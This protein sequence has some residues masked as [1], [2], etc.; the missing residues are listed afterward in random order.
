MSDRKAGKLGMKKVEP[1]ERDILFSRVREPEKCVVPEQFG[2]DDGLTEFFMYGN[3]PESPPPTGAP[4]DFE[5]CGDCFEAGSAEE[6]R[7]WSAYGI[8]SADDITVEQVLTSYEEITGYVLGDE[9]TDQGT[10]PR[11]GLNYRRKTG[12]LD[13]AGARHKIGLYMLGEPGNYEQMLELAL[14]CDGVGLGFDI[15]S[16][17]QEQ[18]ENHEPWDVVP[19]EEIEGGHWVPFRRR[20]DAKTFTVITW[21][22]EQ[23]VTQ[24]FFEKRNNAV[25]G[26]FS[27]ESLK[28]GKNPD[29]L[30]EEALIAEAKKLGIEIV[31][32][33]A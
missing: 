12:I 32:A 19:D 16:S 4:T 30:D 24:A 13:V 14:I 15:P 3:G 29:G 28:A 7:M 25:F 17:A 11:Q 18:F 33:T 22:E 5:G 6:T 10:E 26:I 9:S 23:E 2:G 8:G 27:L 1:D 20:L 21:A 31:G